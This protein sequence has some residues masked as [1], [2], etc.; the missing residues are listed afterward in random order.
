MKFRKRQYRSDEDSQVV[1]LHVFLV[2][3]VVVHTE[4]ARLHSVT[5]V[6]L[7][8]CLHQPRS[9]ASGTKRSTW[10]KSEEFITTE[11]QHS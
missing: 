4:L 6:V 9:G 1:L 11:K 5:C 2:F 10:A 7:V 8:A 3:P